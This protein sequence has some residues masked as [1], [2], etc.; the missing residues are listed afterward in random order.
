MVENTETAVVSL[1]KTNSEKSL[2]K[3][4][5]PSNV[6]YFNLCFEKHLQYDFCG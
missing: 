1:N 6:T 2:N 5:N 4:V 3:F